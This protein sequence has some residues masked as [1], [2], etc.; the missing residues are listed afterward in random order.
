MT[1]WAVVFA[2]PMRL[3]NVLDI[4]ALG[5]REREICTITVPEATHDRYETADPGMG[6][7]WEDPTTTGLAPDHRID[8][9]G[10]DTYALPDDIFGDIGLNSLFSPPH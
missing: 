6:T 7:A 10:C 2:L 9:N 1:R 8:I 5:D 4:A 3:S